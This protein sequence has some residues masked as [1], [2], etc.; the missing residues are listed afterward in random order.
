MCAANANA[1][2]SQQLVR[3]PDGGI[4]GIGMISA[5]EERPGSMLID[6]SSFGPA[7]SKLHMPWPWVSNEPPT[8][9]ARSKT[10][11]NN[12]LETRPDTLV[13]TFPTV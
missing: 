9:D 3:Y 12:Y 8:T 13:R 7:C 4:G 6:D 1:E 5:A 10:I 11:G 2:I